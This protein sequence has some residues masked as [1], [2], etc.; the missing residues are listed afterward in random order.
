MRSI[1][2]NSHAQAHAITQSSPIQSASGARGRWFMPRLLLH[3]LVVLDA[4]V[5]KR[6]VVSGAD[7]IDHEL[8]ARCIRQIE[9]ASIMQRLV[10]SLSQV[11]GTAE[12]A[13]NAN[14][15]RGFFEALARRDWD[16][17][18]GIAAAVAHGDHVGVR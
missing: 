15:G 14:A 18:G 5:L 12:C 10:L 17:F 8:G 2:S 1:T 13:P 16:R 6:R 7:A 4:Q 9:L 11:D 3:V